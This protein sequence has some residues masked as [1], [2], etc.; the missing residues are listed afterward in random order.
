M[1]EEVLEGIGMNNSIQSGCGERGDYYSL[2]YR[3]EW[4]AGRLLFLRLQGRVES[5]ET[6]IPYAIVRAG[7]GET[8]IPY[9]IRESGEFILNAMGESGK[10]T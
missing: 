6:T 2:R 10:S 4:R 3:G 9:A 1:F 8:T 7:S 5:G